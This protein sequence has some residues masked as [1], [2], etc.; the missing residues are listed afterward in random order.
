MNQIF[1]IQRF[2]QLVR[3]DFAERGKNYVMMAGL[4]TGLML[5]L[6]LPILFI[7]FD[8]V[9]MLLHV[10]A[11]FMVVM[12]GGSLYSSAVF[13][14][15]GRSDTGIAAMM[16]PASRFEKFLNAYLVVLLFIV[17]FTIFFVQFHYWSVGYANSRLP[18]GASKYNPVPTDALHYFMY[19]HVMIQG[20]VFLGSICF[21]RLSYIKTASILF[22]LAVFSFGVNI[23]FAYLSTDNPSKI[24]AFPFSGW[25]LWYIGSGRHYNLAHTGAVESLVYAFPLFFLAAT[26]YIGFIRLKEKEI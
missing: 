7:G 6:M 5:A 12:F 25:K 4:L 14:H 9:L 18:V 23:V 22:L 21:S 15:Y 2:I 24:V 1:D 11:L 3:L 10:L 17:P 19:M 13:S 8:T 16:V 20:A 26:W